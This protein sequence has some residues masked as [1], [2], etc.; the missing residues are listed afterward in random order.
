MKRET[1]KSLI[2]SIR[3]IE[4]VVAP[5]DRGQISVKS[6]DKG[7]TVTLTGQLYLVLEKNG[8]AEDGDEW[9]ELKL[10]NLTTGGHTYLEWEEDDEISLTHYT[11]FPSMRELGLDSKD[12]DQFIKT[13]DGSFFFDDTEYFFEEYG[14]AQFF[15]GMTLNS[16]EHNYWNFGDESETGTITIE[17][18]NGDFSASLGH[19]VDPAELE[20]IAKNQ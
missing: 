14:V 18:W 2:S 16:E 15:K 19:Q 5:A 6:I 10:K 9:F 17:Y 1:L 8:Y 7:Y 12:L 3:T 4:G 20:V 13:A 11:Q